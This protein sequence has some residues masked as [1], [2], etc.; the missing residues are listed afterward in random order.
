MKNTMFA[1][2]PC[3]ILAACVSPDPRRQQYISAHPEL[4]V[5]EKDCVSAAI[6]CKGLTRE[7]VRLMWGDPSTVDPLKDGQGE[8]WVYEGEGQFRASS[9]YI[10][11][12]KDGRVKDWHRTQ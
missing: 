11:F 9:D 1:I 3:L 12:D 2:L 4:T 8:Q 7:A 5:E 10:N 6:M